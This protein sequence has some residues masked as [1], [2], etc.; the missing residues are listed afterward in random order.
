MGEGIATLQASP[1]N[2]GSDCF[3]MTGGACQV[4]SWPEGL[5]YGG[6]PSFTTAAACMWMSM[7][8]RCLWKNNVG[9]HGHVHEPEGVPTH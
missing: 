4:L 8:L 1:E 5:G 3:A 9:K 2:R 6:G 7:S